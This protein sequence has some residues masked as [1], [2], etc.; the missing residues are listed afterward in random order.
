MRFSNQRNYGYGRSLCFSAKTAL[1]EMFWKG[2]FSTLKSHCERWR[3]FIS[4]MRARG[5][6]DVRQ[7]D[8]QMLIDFATYLK[9][10]VAIFRFSV[11]YAVNVLSSVNTVLFAMRGNRRI[12]VRPS[13]IGSVSTIRNRV[14]KY[15]NI[16]EVIAKCNRLEI[17]GHQFLATMIQGSAD[18]GLRFKEDF[19]LDAKSAAN[20]ARKNGF[21]D[22]YKGAKGGQKRRFKITSK[23][24]QACLDLSG[25]HQTA[26]NIVPQ[27]KTYA[28]YRRRIYR[29]FQKFGVSGDLSFRELRASF[30]CKEYERLTG[31]PAPI[32]GGSAPRMIDRMARKTIAELL[33]HHRIDICSSYFGK[34]TK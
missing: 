2:H 31:Y 28:Q 29:I 22:I 8:Q 33:G 23:E 15:T 27:N 26:K 17:G 20:S 11:K 12:W 10:Q 34:V 5:V 24:Q 7:V 13:E 4:F 18:L 16:E 3:L 14:P 32:L 21:I 9:E 1:R 6:N 25:H 30:A 19:L